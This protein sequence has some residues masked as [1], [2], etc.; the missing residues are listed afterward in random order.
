MTGVQTCALPI[1]S[2]KA[3]RGEKAAEEKFVGS[4]DWFM[5]SKERS[6]IHNIKVRGEAASTDG[7]AAASYIEDLAQ[8]I[9]EGDYIKQQ[10]FQWRQSS[11]SIG[12]KCQPELS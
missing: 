3:E 8:I 11:P 12:R 4:R 6:H 10:I 1:C 5:K 7:E 9:N 2:L